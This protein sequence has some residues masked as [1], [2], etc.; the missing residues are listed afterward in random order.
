MKHFL[1]LKDK[2]GRFKTYLFS[3][4]H[5]NENG[6]FERVHIQYIHSKTESI[7]Y[8]SIIGVFRTVFCFIPWKKRLFKNRE[9]FS[10]YLIRE[11]EIINHN[12][13]FLLNENG[14]YERVHNK[15]E[16]VLYSSII[17]VF[18]TVF[19]FISETLNHD[20]LLLAIRLL[21]I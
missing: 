11:G 10:K 13:L 18:R 4:K 3:R 7:L 2:I 8:S 16:S 15:T 6:L 20:P 19:R 12:K 9:I 21:K 17:G 14:L 1:P 5:I